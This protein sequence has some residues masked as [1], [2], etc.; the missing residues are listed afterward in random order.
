MRR[1]LTKFL[2]LFILTAVTVLITVFL[3]KTFNTVFKIYDDDNNIPQHPTP[4]T[5]N[6]RIAHPKH[7]AFF[8]GEPKNV[9][10]IKVDWNDYKY[11]EFEKQRTGIGEHGAK[12]FLEPEDE[13]KR[14]TL[15]SQNG[16]NGLLSDR[17]SLNRSVKDIRHKE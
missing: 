3:Y 4:P 2:K 17:I 9:K 10:M 16:F 14:K 8:S 7:G 13:S 11:I 12:A 5:P 15:F 1:N 6:K